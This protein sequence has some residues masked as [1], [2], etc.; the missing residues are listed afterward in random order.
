MD[1]PQNL[2]QLSQTNPIILYDGECY[3]CD[4]T[5]QFILKRDR[6][7]LFRFCS[8]QDAIRY[9]DLSTLPDIANKNSV[10]LIHKGAIFEKSE[11][12]V[13]IMKLLGGWLFY[14]SYL[15]SIIPKFIR[16]IIYSFIARNRYR[17]F[18]KSDTCLIPNP[19]YKS[20]FLKLDL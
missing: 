15:S 2:I 12:V 1:N 20:Q 18:G 5:V 17:W 13:N 8:L 6:N 4:N 11:A 16:N 7:S 10:L 14:L 3:L 19:T 9:S